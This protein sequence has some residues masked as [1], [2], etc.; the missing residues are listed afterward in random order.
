V[1]ETN[2]IEGGT[3]TAFAVNAMAQGTVAL[4]EPL[5][6]G[7]VGARRLFRGRFRSWPRRGE[8]AGAEECSEEEER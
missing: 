8:Q 6:G 5:A 4:E 7:D 2:A 1:V 3:A